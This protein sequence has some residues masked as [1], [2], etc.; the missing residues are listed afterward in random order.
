MHC[1]QTSLSQMQS[2]IKDRVSSG[3]TGS[4]KR[5]RLHWKC[6][7]AKNDESVSFGLI[8]R[9]EAINHQVNASESI[10]KRP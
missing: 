4:S 1:Y 7:S 8:I 10:T 3:M 6:K 9:W 2:H 5:R